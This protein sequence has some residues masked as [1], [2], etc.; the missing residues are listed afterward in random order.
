MVFEQVIVFGVQLVV[1]WVVDGKV[2]LVK[3]KFGVCW[4]VQVEVVDGLVEGDVVVMVGQ[5][6]LCDGVVVCVVGGG[7][8]VVNGVVVK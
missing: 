3:V 4:V 2:V 5:L 6:K 8:L 7:V 1:F